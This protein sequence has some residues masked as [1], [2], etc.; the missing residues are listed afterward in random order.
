VQ[1]LHLFEFNSDRKRMSVV[2]RAGGRVR[3]YCKGADSIISAR[4]G[5][6]QPFLD[7]IQGQIDEFS[8]K[9]LRTLLFA[10]KDLPEEDY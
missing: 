9:G 1:L 5:P 6:R 4:L 7:S 10:V 8:R 3:V 2:V